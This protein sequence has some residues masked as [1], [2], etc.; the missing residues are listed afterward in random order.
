[1]GRIEALPKGNTSK[2]PAREIPTRLAVRRKKPV[3]VFPARSDS[4]D[5]ARSEPVLA[6]KDSPA[7]EKARLVVDAAPS[8]ALPALPALMEGEMASNRRSRT[9]RKLP[10][11]PAILLEGDLP[12]ARPTQ[13]RPGDRV[14]SLGPAGICIANPTG[15]PSIPSPT[16]PHRPWTPEFDNPVGDVPRLEPAS[17][18]SR[19][20]TPS[21]PCGMGR[22]GGSV[23]LTARDPHCFL[24]YWTFDRSALADWAAGFPSGGWEWR[25]HRLSAGGA[26][27]AS[28]PL[29]G[30]RDHQFL[31]VDLAGVLHVV[32][33]GFRHSDGG[34]TS[35]GCSQPVATPA[36]RTWQRSAGS[37][38]IEPIRWV[39][40]SPV[41]DGDPA[42]QLAESWTPPSSLP[43][44]LL[45]E[46]LWGTAVTTEALGSSEQSDRET[47]TRGKR[48]R[49]SLRSGTAVTGEGWLGD[50][51][52]EACSVSSGVL[53][54]APSVA[55][56]RFWFRVNAEV[57][58]HGSTEPNATV[59]IAGIRVPLRPDGSFTFR[60]A[61]P[62]GDFQLP[63]VAVSSSGD[64][65]RAAE[66]RFLRDTRTSGEVG[67]LPVD[68]ALRAP[69]AAS[70]PQAAR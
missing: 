8:A 50:G 29:P 2:A 23:W 61:L 48:T 57:V 67:V 10:P 26:V 1:M 39:R 22:P 66:V 44:E 14:E 5:G 32:Q 37:V 54:E 68:P 12:L 65:A 24:L 30:D 7:F 16:E 3:P 60:F 13:V 45:E 53:A 59:T 15:I 11:L 70:L 62:D 46:V 47:D 34:W 25:L 27:A 17:A 52:E 36:D 41:L 35:V 51:E 28:G 56:K 38:A 43:T 4:T 55:E 19:A 42:L 6:T 49:K 9:S 33:I 21:A 63:A 40:V 64:D 69:V 31:P 20:V 58:L 18:S